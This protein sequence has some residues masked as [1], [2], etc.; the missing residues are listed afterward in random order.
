LLGQRRRRVLLR[1]PE[2][3]AHSPPPLAHPRRG[4][5]RRLRVHRGLLQST[6]LTLVA[7]LQ[8]ACRGRTGIR[9]GGIA[10]VNAAGGSPD[11][12][13]PT[14]PAPPTEKT[15]PPPPPP[16]PRPDAPTTIAPRCAPA[17]PGEIPSP[18]PPPPAARPRA[19]CRYRSKIVAASAF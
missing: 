15:P 1:V 9:P 6:S 5:Q 2:K 16:P 10:A 19:P 13:P 17:T 18:T 11:P 12:V 4:P 3:R 8:D 7:Q 14:A